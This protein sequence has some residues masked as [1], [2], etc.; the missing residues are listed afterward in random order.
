M[1]VPRLTPV[2]VDDE[3]VRLTIE[4]PLVVPEISNTP[5]PDE[6]TP[7]EVAMLPLPDSAN[8]PPFTAVAPV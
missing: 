7:E 8:V 5:P 6:V 1:L 2:A 4:A 3:P